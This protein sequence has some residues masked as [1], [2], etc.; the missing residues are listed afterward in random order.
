MKILRYFELCPEGWESF[1]RW[2][3]AIEKKS[4][5]APILRLAYLHHRQACKVC[6]HLSAG[7]KIVAEAEAEVDALIHE[8]A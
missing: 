3:N 7:D 4:A 5:G 1:D 8:T 2:H 6:P